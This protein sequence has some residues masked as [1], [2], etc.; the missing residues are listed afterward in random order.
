M[1]PDLRVAEHPTAEGYLLLGQQ[2]Q[3]AGRVKDARAAYNKALQSD[4]KTE[5]AHL[6]LAPC[7]KSRQPTGTSD[8]ILDM[9]KDIAVG[10]RHGES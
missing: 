7:R 1:V 8:V 2:Q 3:Q 10:L 6:A 9:D 4:P 5:A